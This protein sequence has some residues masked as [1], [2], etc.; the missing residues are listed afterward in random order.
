[1]TDA[2]LKTLFHPFE[3]E[4]LD[5]PV[6]G[7]RVLFHNAPAGLRQPQSLSGIDLDIVQDFRP[8]FLALQRAGHAVAPRPEGE[9]YDAA[10][11]LAGRHRGQNELWIADAVRRVKKGG[12]IV[13][14]GANGDGA[15]SLRKRIGSLHPLADHAAKHHGTVFWLTTTEKSA[16]LASGLELA[17][18]PGIAE[19]FKTAPGMFSHERADRGSQLL[20]EHLPGDLKGRAADFGAGWGYLSVELSRRSPGISSIDL[21]EAGHAASEAARANMA[22]LATGMEAQVS[23]CDL[24]SEPPARRY[25]VIVMNPPFHEGAK[26]DPQIG[27]AMIAAAAKALSP[28]GRL[29]AVANAHLPYEEVFARSFARHVELARRDGFKVIMAQR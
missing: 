10:F 22:A 14:G 27:V 6:P 11:V 7:A 9:G 12:L 5:P 23:W 21:F 20:A 17:N 18:P 1:M 8:A 19:G 2:P 24:A 25:D 26:G 3:A 16:E 4:L 29:Y 13:V 28:R 15:A